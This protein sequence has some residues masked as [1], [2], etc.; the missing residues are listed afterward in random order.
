ME[1]SQL[2]YFLEVA[3]SQHITKSAEKLHIAQPALSQ[4]IHRLEKDLG[5]PLFVSKGRNIVLTEYG[6]YLRDRLTPLMASLEDIPH[7]LRTMARVEGHTIHL[8]VLAATALVTEAIIAYRE[9]H[10]DI[11]FQMMQNAES[12]LYDICITTRLLYQMAETETGDRYVCG[13]Q[14]FLA[15]PKSHPFA[16]LPSVTLSQAAGE[17]FISLMG[18]RQLRWICDRYCTHAG[19]TPRIVFESDSPAAVQNMIA[20]SMGIGF[21]PEFTW[22]RV[23]SSR[24]TLLPITDPICRRDL[25]I[26]RKPGR[27]NRAVDDFYEFLIQYFSSARGRQG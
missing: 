7:R 6:K 14:I 15:V 9:H 25:L 21:W 18:S 3:E 1:L 20:A 19:F 23:D 17:G 16:A 27:D 13:E 26:D 5:V 22:G 12:D 24:V 4:S 8:N 11:H 2:Q 10:D